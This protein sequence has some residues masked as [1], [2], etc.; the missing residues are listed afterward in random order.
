MSLFD[1]IIVISTATATRVCENEYD[2]TEAGWCQK[3]VGRCTPIG[4]VRCSNQDIKENCHLSCS[5]CT[6]QLGKNE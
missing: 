6:L 5:N 3:N 1:V 4:C 2:K